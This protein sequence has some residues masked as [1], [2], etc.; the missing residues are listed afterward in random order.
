M[1]LSDRL[2]EYVAAAFTGIWVH[3]FEP[4]DA[5][6]DVAR[7]CR[8]RSWALA[9]WDVDRGLQVAGRPD[10]ADDGAAPDPVAAVRALDAMATPDG[11]AILVLVNAHRVLSSAE[12]VQAV[13]R[14]VQQGKTNRT[15]VVVL[16]PV[17]QLPVELE[18]HFVV[19]EH[20]LPD[21]PQLEA[22]AR[23]VATEPG[24]LT[25]GE[26]LARL[27][28]AAAGLTRHEAEGAFALS[29]VRHGRLDPRA[30]W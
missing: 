10:A 23:G 21:R 6:A 3:S 24:E 7:L 18:R 8:D 20:D 12:V 2:A 27:L 16:S 28:D 25:A 14:Q 9:T 13:A 26:D 30:G 29:L 22:I 17:V 15:F 19:V 4:A 11:S 1:T 5:L